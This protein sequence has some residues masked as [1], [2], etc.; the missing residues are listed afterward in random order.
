MRSLNNY[1]QVFF[2]QETNDEPD[3]YT[4]LLIHWD[5]DI[6]DSSLLEHSITNYS[7]NISNSEKVIWDWSLYFAWWSNYLDIQELVD[8]FNFDWDYT[9]DFWMKTNQNSLYHAWIQFL[10]LTDVI[11][12]T[13]SNRFLYR[14]NWATV[15][16][17]SWNADWNW[18][19]IAIVRYW[20]D[21][22]L[23]EDWF[24]TASNTTTASVLT[25][26]I[27]LWKAPITDPA[28][29]YVGYLDEFRV[30]KWIARW[31]ENFTPM[32]EPY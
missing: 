27:Y 9:I 12:Y 10:Q 17:N 21:L 3:D 24:M 32:S 30:S 7:V 11:S 16:W 1:T 18:H 15:Q 25:N 6:K 4:V 31:T 26:Y 14:H 29:A 13:D 19:H 5:T 23:F 22:Y 20:N 2:E 28:D 8:E